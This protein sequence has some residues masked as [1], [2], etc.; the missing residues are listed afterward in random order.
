MV[1][2]QGILEAA[3]SIQRPVV[4]GCISAGAYACS[5]SASFPGGGH[6]ERVRVLER[7]RR[8]QGADLHVCRPDN[9][10]SHGRCLSEVPHAP[11][12]RLPS[13]G[14]WPV[15]PRTGPKRP[16][17]APKSVSPAESPEG[18]R[19]VAH[20]FGPTTGT[21]ANPLGAWDPQRG[22]SARR[23][24]LPG[25]VGA[26]APRFRGQNGKRPKP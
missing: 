22:R 18:R 24:L 7:R 26:F 15:R 6:L 8:H 11:G 17:N 23:S 21:R 9:R 5:R 14:K 10:S 3:R 20:L 16:Q 1:Q 13:Q 25:G 19:S 2:L 4:Q 12:H